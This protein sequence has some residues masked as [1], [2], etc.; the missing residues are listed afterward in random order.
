M[1]IAEEETA[2]PMRRGGEER[3]ALYFPLLPGKRRVIIG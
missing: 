2:R 3:A 1:R